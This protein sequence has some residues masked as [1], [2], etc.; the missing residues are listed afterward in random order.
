MNDPSAESRS[1]RSRHQI[2]VQPPV[3]LPMTNDQRDSAVRVLAALLLPVVR[4]R[5]LDS[6]DRTEGSSAED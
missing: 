4:S 5:H 2:H 1:R 3:L 6:V